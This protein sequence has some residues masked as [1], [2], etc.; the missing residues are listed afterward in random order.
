MAFFLKSALTLSLP[1]F[2]ATLLI[3][4]LALTASKRGLLTLSRFLTALAIVSGYSVGHRIATGSL[5]LFPK[6][7]EGWLPLLAFLVSLL[8]L[9]ENLP[10]VSALLRL[11]P[12]LILGL[13]AI[14]VLLIPLAA[15]SVAAKIVWAVVLGLGFAVVWTGLDELS[16]RQTDALLPL[17]LSLIAATNS[18]ALFISHSAQLSQLS[19]VL[20]SAVGAIFVFCLWQRHWSMAKGASG[21]FVLL[22]FGI[23]TCCMFYA[24]LPL[25]S[26]VFFL[27]A[28]LS[29]WVR[30]LLLTSKLPR[31]SQLT[32]QVAVSLLL[33]FVGVG[34]A[35]YK[36]GLPMGGYY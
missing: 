16:E 36:N 9:F 24:D 6:S 27:L 26:L 31:W 10:K 11:L 8:S 13:I 3:L 5:E 21:V 29:G 17:L 23:N 35:I 22:L 33:A 19:G 30:I 32:L 12:R 34:I 2:A 18:A 15:L 25:L 7:V 4:L 14:A 1:P 28:P 20:A